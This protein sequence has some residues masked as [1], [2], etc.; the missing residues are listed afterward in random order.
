[1]PAKRMGDFFWCHG[2][3][4]RSKVVKKIDRIENLIKWVT[5]LAQRREFPARQDT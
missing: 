3:L 2:F 4:K 1:M 5:Y